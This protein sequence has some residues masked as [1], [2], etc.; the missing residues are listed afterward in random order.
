MIGIKHER[1]EK[2][3]FPMV[4]G[5]DLTRA[6]AIIRTRLG[7]LTRVRFQVVEYVFGRKP[8]GVAV[9]DD[10]TIVLRYDAKYD[11][12]ALTPRFYGTIV[13]PKKEDFVA[14]DYDWSSTEDELSVSN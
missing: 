4:V 6:K 2:M 13:H 3:E 5:C 9:A 1:G 11:A 10:N 14:E 12:V 8:Q 7:P